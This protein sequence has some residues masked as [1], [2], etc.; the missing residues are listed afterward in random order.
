MSVIP[1]SAL[2]LP[3]SGSV[4]PTSTNR[5]IPSR[6]GRGN[7]NLFSP[8]GAHNNNALDQSLSSHTKLVFDVDELKTIFQSQSM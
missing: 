2:P 5:R 4:S 8:S 3:P 1:S 7:N 6:D